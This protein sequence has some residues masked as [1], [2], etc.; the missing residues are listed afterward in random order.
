MSFMKDKNPKSK[1]GPDKMVTPLHIAAA[2]GHLE[3]CN[4]IMEQTADKNPVDSNGWTPLHCAAKEG[5]IQ[6]IKAIHD[7]VLD[8]NP[9]DKEGRTPMALFLRHA[10]AEIMNDIIWE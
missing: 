4:A 8:K 7:H 9:V 5:H 10:N 1:M 3:I 2:Y 6:I